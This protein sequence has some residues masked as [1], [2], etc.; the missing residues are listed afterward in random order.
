MLVIGSIWKI[1]DLVRAPHDRVL[2]LLVACLLLLAAGEIL[3]YP[4]A[5][6]AVDSLT[7]LG[8]GKIAF[9]AIYMSGLAALILFFVSSTRRSRA[10][11]RRHLRIHTSL[12]AGVVIALVV[13]M[14]ATPPAMR[15]HTLTT[16]HM[17]QPGIA[18]FY[19]IGNAYFLYAYATSGSW[20]LRY[21]RMAGR[22][23]AL[24]LRTTALG[25][26]GLAI[27][28]VNRMI[29]VFLRI[30]H[31]VSHQ[32]FN[33]VNWSLN[34]W[35]MGV[36]LIG[37]SYSASVQLIAH[38]RS[39]VRHRRMYHELTPLWTAL[40][41]AYPELILKREPA[42]SRWS[43]LRVR[44]TH[45]RFYR[46]LIECRDGLVRLSPYV[47]RVAPDADL[48]RG[49]AEHLARYICQA[50]ALKPSAEDPDTAFSAARVAL[51]TENDLGADARE[52]IAISHAYAERQS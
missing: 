19:L 5:N 23:L 37:I 7:A 29:W 14:T 16:A 8:V 28:S 27:T 44:R 40:A 12:L 9:N 34:D 24:G 2:R 18:S 47:A 48:A 39:V 43:R 33:T 20:A 21:A 46:R 17:A 52:L 13:S 45:E 42:R 38:L 49:R 3:S 22:H 31:P 15:G 50:L 6:S 41:G 4:Q 11:Y 26:F 10:R 25:L 30:N 36:V 32:A 35:S 51:P 1:I